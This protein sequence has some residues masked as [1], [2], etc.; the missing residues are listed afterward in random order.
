MGRE[1]VFVI[2]PGTAGRAEIGDDGG[3]CSDGIRSKVSR[4]DDIVKTREVV[5]WNRELGQG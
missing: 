2:R 4:S 3:K 1:T 5:S